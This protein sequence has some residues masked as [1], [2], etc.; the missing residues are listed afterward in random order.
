MDRS[1]FRCIKTEYCELGNLREW[2][3]RKE[4]IE[5]RK[6]QKIDIRDIFNQV[7]NSILLH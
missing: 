5:D 6:E 3:E 4:T 2:L 1:N 7:N